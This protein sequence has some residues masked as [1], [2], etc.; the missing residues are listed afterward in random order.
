M[1][2]RKRATLEPTEHEEQAA[3]L[4]W[5]ATVVA[6]SESVM[7]VATGTA[8]PMAHPLSLLFA[9][10]NAGGFSGGF[11]A[12][13]ARVARLKRE[14]VKSGV[15]DLMLP[16]PRGGHNGLFLEL[17]RAKGGRVAPA[18]R[19][20]HL[21]LMGQGY[22]VLTAQGAEAAIRAIQQYLRLPQV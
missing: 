6:G 16:V 15:P 5:A 17:K 21:A 7:A 12:N 1:T 14:G 20:W 19:A 18:Q 11:R 9:I 8:D 2:A 10:P 13:V 22:L 3:V 4:R